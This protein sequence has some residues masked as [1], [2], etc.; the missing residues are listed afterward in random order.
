MGWGC[1]LAGL[2]LFYFGVRLLCRISEIIILDFSDWSNKLEVLHRANH[3]P[4][5]NIQTP[6]PQILKRTWCFNVQNHCGVDVSSF[7]GHWIPQCILLDPLQ[8]TSPVSTLPN[9]S[10]C[11]FPCKPRSV[12]AD[13]HLRHIVAADH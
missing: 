7:T 13:W 1:C 10:V 2:L 5:M 11:L 9:G 6:A 12:S 4:T 3:N 8:G